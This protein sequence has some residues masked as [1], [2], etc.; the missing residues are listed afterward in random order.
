MFSQLWNFLR[1][2]WN[3]FSGMLL[4]AG[5]LWTVI[6]AP[7]NAAGDAAANGGTAPRAGFL[8]PALTLNDRSGTA[9]TLSSLRGRPV[10]V[11]FWASWCPPCKAEMAAIQAVYAA[12]AGQGFTV[13]AVDAA[14]QD[15]SGDMNAFV[16][17]Q[18]L[19][20]P[21]LLDTTGQAAHA[22]QVTA[23][24]SSYF[25]DP[26]GRVHHVVIGGPMAEALLRAQ[27][28][29]MLRVPLEPPAPAGGN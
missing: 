24:P 16:E 23:F 29:E 3:T 28:E 18:R 10:L 1:P 6:C 20:F 12:Y 25:I 13:L 9:V 7:T 8:A 2:R 11:N 4:F 22:Y 14:Y 5:A 15:N 17:N 27:V 26:N 19:T 21:I